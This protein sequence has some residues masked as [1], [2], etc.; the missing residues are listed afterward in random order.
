MCSPDSEMALFSRN[1]INTPIPNHTVPALSSFVP[2]RSLL[3][4]LPAAP[5]LPSLSQSS[6]STASSEFTP[7]MAAAMDAAVIA[8]QR[9]TSTSSATLAAPSSDNFG[10][11]EFTPSMADAMDVIERNSSSNSADVT[12][13]VASGSK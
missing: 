13:P 10:S 9:N 1:A 2:A 12:T 5:L 8:V 4:S 3:P 6:V 7:S 11:D